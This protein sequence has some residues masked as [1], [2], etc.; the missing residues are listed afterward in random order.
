MPPRF[1]SRPKGPPLSSRRS[2]L[3]QRPRLPRSQSPRLR[4]R[5]QSRSRLH[6]RRRRLPRSRALLRHSRL[7]RRSRRGPRS[8]HVKRARRLRRLPGSRRCR[9]ATSRSGPSCQRLHPS[10]WL[11]SRSHWPRLPC[12]RQSRPR[13]L[14]QLRL[15]SH[16]NFM[17]RGLRPQSPSLLFLSLFLRRNSALRNL[18]PGP[19]RRRPPKRNR[20]RRRRRRQLRHLPSLSQPRPRRLWWCASPNHRLP[21]HRPSR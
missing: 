7:R 15:S 13:P 3:A 16:R 6:P 17:G 20:S 10:S 1:D 2:P 14:P 19:S 11:S 18:S 12:S 4:R 21:L 5:F 8:R 9:K